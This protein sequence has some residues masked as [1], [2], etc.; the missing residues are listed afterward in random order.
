MQA[1][2]ERPATTLSCTFRSIARDGNPSWSNRF[3]RDHHDLVYQ[4]DHHTIARRTAQRPKPAKK[5][6]KVNPEEDEV[7]PEQYKYSP[8]K[9]RRRNGVN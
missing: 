5:G 2:K 6:A 4:T 3:V 7:V 9:Q 8:Q 1:S